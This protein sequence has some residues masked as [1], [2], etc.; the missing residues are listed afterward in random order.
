MKNTLETR[1][2]LFFALALVAAV[3]ILE[4][5]GGLA[6]IR[7]GKH[8]HALFRNAHELKTGD[9]VKMAGVSVGRVEKLSIDGQKVKVTLKLDA[10]ADVRTDSRAGIKAASMLGGQN[11]VALEFGTG[12][13][14]APDA[15]LDTY[16]Q[17]DI[18]ALISRM[19]SVA[20]GI[21][22]VTRSFSGD[23]ID[24][25]L[26]PFTDFMKQNNQKLGA[27]FG[28]M[29]ILSEHMARGEGTLGRLIKDDA[30]YQST[31]GTVTNLQAASAD[32]RATIADVRARLH[33]ADTLIASINTVLTNANA[34]VMSDDKLYNEAGS[35][36]TNLREILEKVNK[37]QGF[38]GKL[39]NDETLFK[40]VKMTLQK[41]DKATEGLED[42]GPLS[43]LGTAVNTLF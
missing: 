7:P 17:P 1:L 8:V 2:G 43:V 16:E 25:I 14:I 24:N 34:V 11:Y 30:L 5:V 6:F 42:T 10:S 15:I 35:A 20:G 4:M 29:Q 32:T 18:N 21:E 37:G 39:V 40:N 9:A 26:G 33:Q 13:P 12:S 36:L 31:L 19:D 22:N 41:V 27:I 23:K 3:I 38:A 28:N